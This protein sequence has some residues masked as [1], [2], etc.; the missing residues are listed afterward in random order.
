MSKFQTNRELSVVV[1]CYRAEDD[2]I[3]FVKQLDDELSIE[4]VDFEL[5][6][7]ANY[8]R[9]EKD[10]T[11]DIVKRMAERNPR[12]LVVSKEKEGKMGW[13]MRSGMAAA[14]GKYIAVIDG[15]GQMPSSD[16]GLVYKIIKEGNYDLV[17]TYRAKRFDG[18]YRAVLSSVYNLLFKILF[19]PDFVVNDINSK[20]KVMT[21]MAYEKM[22][23]VSNDWFTDAEIMIEAFKNK[24]KICEVAAVFY[25]NERRRSF[26]GM[27]TVFEFIFNLIYYKL[28]R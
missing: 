22:K 8:E 26:V 18:I 11:P 16:I 19:R 4:N 23:L 14:T 24:L 21:R 17:K 28:K 1:L 25:K 27:K 9:N 3:S 7:V 10:T 6:L 5:V 15:D 12:Y 20:P 2:I 13:D